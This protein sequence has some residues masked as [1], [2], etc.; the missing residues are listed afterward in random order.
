[1]KWIWKGF[2]RMVSPQSYYHGQYPGLVTIIPVE[3]T[4]HSWRRAPR[5]GKKVQQ[6]SNPLVSI[7]SVV[8]FYRH[9]SICVVLSI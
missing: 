4:F 3:E 6:E 9:L 1:M 5:L 8:L 2:G 7:V